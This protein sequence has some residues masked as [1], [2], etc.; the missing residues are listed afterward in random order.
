MHHS[1]DD[2]L[3]YV[4]RST[5]PAPPLFGDPDLELTDLVQALCEHYGRPLTLYLDDD[6]DQAADER[7]GAP[8]LRLLDGM[9]AEALR[10]WSLSDRWIGAGTEGGRVFVAVAER[11]LPTERYDPSSP[12]A[13]YV[14]R[15][16]ELTGWTM[17]RTNP[18][19]WP[20]AEARL[21]TPLPADYKE[22]IEVFGGGQFN[23][24]I[25]LHQPIRT[26][27]WSTLDI[28][29]TLHEPDGHDAGLDMDWHDS[30]AQARSACARQP[31][32]KVLL[33]WAGC[34]HGQLLWHVDGADPAGWPALAIGETFD[35]WTPMGASA[36]EALH[37]ILTDPRA[38]FSLAKYYDRHWF[39]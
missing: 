17:D 3:R 1:L 16:V 32:G 4:A 33:P 7:T 5:A 2:L 38:P 15:V 28:F 8:L 34:E 26:G 35:D 18:V 27:P 6:A 37:R 21:G 19:D 31:G 25:S 29:L 23:D 39:G 10:A 36:A 13:S 24:W 20:E 30:L 11:V 12:D 14:E 9:D 22:L